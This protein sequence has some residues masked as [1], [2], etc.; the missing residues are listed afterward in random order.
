MTFTYELR[1]TYTV[2]WVSETQKPYTLAFIEIKKMWKKNPHNVLFVLGFTSSSEGFVLPVDIL[3]CCPSPPFKGLLLHS[4]SYHISHQN[5]SFAQLP[6]LPKP[7]WPPCVRVWACVCVCVM[8][9]QR[10]FLIMSLCM[11]IFFCCCCWNILIRF[12]VSLT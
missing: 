5:G 4:L 1:Q 12:T 11:T 8:K 2:R 3:P 10:M 7:T 6:E 9:L